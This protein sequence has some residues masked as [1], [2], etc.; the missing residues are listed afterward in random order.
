MT[1]S[2]IYIS[3]SIRGKYG[4]KATFAQ[5]EANNQKALRFG[6]WLR[7]SFSTAKFYVPCEL[8]LLLY[9][10]GINPMNIVN[11]LLI[12]D[13]A[14]VKNCD[15]IIFYMP[16]DYLSGGMQRE[17]TEA[18]KDNKP[19]LNMPGELLTISNELPE[20]EGYNKI[21]QFISEIHNV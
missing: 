1:E 10:A 8:D 2:K 16:D 21:A 7:D 4:N 9:S 19:M 3:H 12:L 14:I 15:G 5:M 18:L 13:C 6:N 11:E 20:L 17:K